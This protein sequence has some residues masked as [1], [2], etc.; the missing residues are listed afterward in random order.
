MMKSMGMGGRTMRGACSTRNNRAK[1]GE[2][3]SIQF[4][5]EIL[6]SWR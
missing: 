4:F 6:E 3:I 5:H 2:L 1:Y